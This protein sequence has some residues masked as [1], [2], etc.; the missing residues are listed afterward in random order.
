MNIMEPTSSSSSIFL[1]LSIT[2][3]Y[4]LNLFLYLLVNNYMC[5]IYKINNYIY[6]IPYIWI[7]KT[8]DTTL[9]V[10]NN[11]IFIVCILNTISEK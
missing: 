5:L 1:V 7:W 10:K 11:I 8:N 2:F 6:I 9:F 3:N 4:I